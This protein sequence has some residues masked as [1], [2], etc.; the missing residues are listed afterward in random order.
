MSDIEKKNRTRISLIVLLI[1]TLFIATAFWLESPADVLKGEWKIL[2]STG[3]LITDYI[4]LAGLGSAFFNA[5]IMT[6]VGLVVAWIIK[7]RFNGL[8]LSGI[9][10]VTGF[11]FFGKN[12]FNITPILIGV[13]LFD[14]FIA[15]ERS[16]N[17]IAPILFGTALAPVVSQFAFG[18]GWG[19][20]GI[21]AG[22]VVGII[23]G[24]LLHA[25][26]GHIITFH[27]GYNLYNI[28]TTAGFIGMVVYIM[29]WGFGLEVNSLFYWSTQHTDFLT[30]YVL[31]LI[32]LLIILG[33]AWGG[34]LTNYR[35]IISSSGRLVSD[36]V[37]ELDLGTTLINM[38]LIG[39]MGLGYVRLVN[40]DVNGPILAGIFTV[41]GFGGLGKHPR[42]IL[43][44]MVGIYI[45]CLLKIWVH[46]DPGPLLAALF[47]TTLAPLSGRFG[48]FA[49]FIA[50]F[51]HLPMVMHVGSVHGFMN[52]YNNGF[53]GGLATLLIIGFLQGVRPD[54][55]D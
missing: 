20:Y 27:H 40:G 37:E 13:Y 2:N 32:A 34:T 55:L 18:N 16:K 24:I 36:Y 41:M 45:S 7:A 21:A 52:L 50:G 14:R 31:G 26:M 38:G 33:I 10:T 19:W 25:V 43:P 53:A 29:M 5:G 6:L 9:L 17:L 28:G 15:R 48:F 30:Y 8:L 35:K 1:G 51:L 23:C 39:L 3:V 12:P 44:I 46:N 49:G 22:F 11:S 4:E 47:C 42:N 54:L